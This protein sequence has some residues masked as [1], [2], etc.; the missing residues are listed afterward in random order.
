VKALLLL[1]LLG[2]AAL[3]APAEPVPLVVFTDPGFDIDDETALL[4][5]AALHKRGQ[6][7]LRLVVATTEPSALRARLAKGLFQQTG[8]G[9]VPVAT[10]DSGRPDGLDPHPDRL[11]TSFLA[12]AG[13]VSERADASFATTLSQAQDGSLV[14][15]VLAKMTDANRFL[16]DD[17]ELF[18]RKVKKVVIM[19]GVEITE[20]GYRADH[21]S[22]NNTHD[23]PAADEFYAKLQAIGIP[24]TIVTRFAALATPIPPEFFDQLQ[25]SGQPVAGH[26]S[27]L[28]G[29]FLNDFWQAARHG[30]LGKERDEAWFL[31]SFCYPN[32]RVSPDED[33]R[34]YLKSRVLYDAVAL[35]A[36]VEPLASEY[37]QP[38]PLKPDGN[39]LIGPS[40]DNPG[41]R[42]PHKLAALI[43]EL[44]KE[45][46]K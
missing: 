17:P 11:Q 44:A 3:A 2:L 35:I 27:Q 38:L 29:L 31:S 40:P 25:A 23:Q 18:R 1:A 19:G 6:I 34:P 10:G 9:D 15:L 8:L 28:E 30:K 4:V 7:S 20:Q 46:T 37:F 21:R 33:I 14:L 22:T 36:A 26:L 39:Y 5:A 24:A 13:D 43:A 12:A 42:D 32:A 45:A 41:L 16:N